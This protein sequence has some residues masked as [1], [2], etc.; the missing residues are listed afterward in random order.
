MVPHVWLL[1]SAMRSAI[2]C[3]ALCHALRH[4]VLAG[5]TRFLHVRRVHRVRCL[6]SASLNETEWKGQ[7][8][9]YTQRTRLLGARQKREQD[10]REERKIGGA[11][12]R[13]Y[14]QNEKY[15]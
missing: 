8:Y 14:N 12:A 5:I 2:V 9:A 15:V 4:R 3:H 13:A 11:R 10:G 6:S 1:R 7:T